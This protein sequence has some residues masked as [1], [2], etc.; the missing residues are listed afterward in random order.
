ML[1]TQPKSIFL[2]DEKNKL[3]CHICGEENSV[4]LKI[5]NK[6]LQTSD[7]IYCKKCKCVIF[8][9]M[10]IKYRIVNSIDAV[11]DIENYL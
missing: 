6:V 9:E 5:I 3:I 4:M 2:S 7:H 11:V 1:G 10:E 8:F